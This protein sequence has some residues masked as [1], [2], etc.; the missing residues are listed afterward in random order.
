MVEPMYFKTNLKQNAVTTGGTRVAYY[1]ASRPKV[2][3][4]AGNSMA[5]APGPQAVVNPIIKV[6]DTKKLKFS[7]PVGKQ[8]GLILFLQ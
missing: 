3:T 6:L 4:Y 8:A 1:D 5:A 7:Y 2:E